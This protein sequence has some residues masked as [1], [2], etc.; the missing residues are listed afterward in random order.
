MSRVRELAAYAEWFMGRYAHRL[1]EGGFDHNLPQ[2]APGPPAEA[3]L[4][5]ER[6]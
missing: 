5:V 2:E 3:V 4:D 6:L 1:I